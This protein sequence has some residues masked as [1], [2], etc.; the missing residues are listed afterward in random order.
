MFTEKQIDKE[1]IQNYEN[2]F[3][4]WLREVRLN[5]QESDDIQTI[6]ENLASLARKYCN[7]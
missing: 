4:N 5:G 3:I 2:Q 1:Y 7:D 6:V